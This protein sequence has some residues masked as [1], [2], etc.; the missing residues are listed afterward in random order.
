MSAL[1]DSV[2]SAHR[3]SQ[4]KIIVINGNNAQGLCVNTK[5][6]DYPYRWRSSLSGLDL[7]AI[8]NRIF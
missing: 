8:R 4:V 6:A 7:P 5:H 1:Q 3:K 2:W